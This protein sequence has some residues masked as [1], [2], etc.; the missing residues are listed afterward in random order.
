MCHRHHH[1]HH[2][3]YCITLTTSLPRHPQRSLQGAQLSKQIFVRAPALDTIPASQLGLASH[4]LARHAVTNTRW[5]AAH[6]PQQEKA[7]IAGPSRL[8]TASVPRHAHSSSHSGPGFIHAAKRGPLSTNDSRTVAPAPSATPRKTQKAQYS[9]RGTDASPR[10]TR[11]HV[12]DRPQPHGSEPGPWWTGET[13]FTQ[14]DRTCSDAMLDLDRHMAASHWPFGPSRPQDLYRDA[15]LAHPDRFDWRRRCTV[16]S[17]PVVRSGSKSTPLQRRK[18]SASML[19]G[20]ESKFAAKARRTAERKMDDRSFRMSREKAAQLIQRNGERQPIREQA[21]LY[22]QNWTQLL[23]HERNQELAAIA[24]RRK[25]PIDKLV[26]EGIAI[27]GLQ[28]YWQDDSRRHFGKKVAVFKLDAAEPLPRTLFRAGDK[29]TIMPSTTSGPY[30]GQPL[31]EEE[32]IEAEVVERQRTFLR[33]KFDERDEDVDLVACPSWRLDYG[34]NDLTF[35]RIKAALEAIEHDVEFIETQYGSRFQYILSGTRLSDVILGIEP[36]ADRVT[37]GAFWEDARVQSWY[38]RFSRPDPVVVDGDPQPQLNRSQTQAVAMML[39]ERVSLI[40]GPPGTGKTRTIVTAIKLLKQEFQ[41]P[42]PVML[43]AHTNV[44]VDNLADG[45][46]KA[47][48]RVVRIGPS[49]RARA[50][51]DEF[52]LDAHFLRHPAKPRLDDIKRRMDTLEKLKSDY[53]MVRGPV[54]APAVRDEGEEGI[55][56]TGGGAALSWEDVMAEREEEREV[57]QLQGGTASEEYESIKKRL[58][59]LKATYFFLRASIRGE[60]LNGA[61]VICGSAIAAGSPELDMIDLPV[62]FFDEASMATEPVSLVPLMKGCRHLS[63]IGDHKQLP[64]VVTSAE[65]K[66]GGL[67]KSLFERLI[68]STAA[69]GSKIPSTMLNVQFRMHPRLAEFPNKT[70]YSGALENGS[71]TDKIPAV[72]SEYWPQVEGKDEAHRLCFIDHKGR[73]SK[74]DNSLSLCNVAE[75][76]LAVDVAMDVLRRNPDLTGDDIGIVTP[77][78]GQQILLEKMLHNDTSAERRRAAGALGAR[79]SQL[80]CIDVHTV[81]GFEGREK[82]VILFSTVRTNAQGYV[83][84]LADGRRLNVALTRAQ[85]A[86]FVLG[87]IDTF[88][89]AQLSEA[90][91][92]RVESPDLGALKSYAEYLEQQGAVY[93]TGQAHKIVDTA[94]HDDQDV[95]AAETHSLADAADWQHVMA[96]RSSA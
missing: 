41:V 66:Q 24:E 81:D 40:Q 37:R 42:H 30:A 90:A 27:D 35:E 83:G 33:L 10:S 49:A 67:S 43:A 19:I 28:A 9:R 73:E 57:A 21:R 96:E 26:D 60:I 71:G 54:A 72:E 23:D 93:T 59:R 1:D 65:A 91:Y 31:A 86:L 56:A 18:A 78:A 22:R 79:S 34:F 51:I 32:V 75:A 6:L 11:A 7:C 95:D 20:E 52:T 53:E 39:R 70:F 2:Y 14:V 61:D 25:A 89:N 85:S 62:V 69:D 82:K 38:D 13:S 17:Q 48:L 46:I 94:E 88:K 5:A 4:H 76:R 15:Y 55:G 45:C 44:A 80:G 77:Y 29:V 92:S 50:G 36:P 16:P 63:I 64:P 74:A 8:P 47:G 68:E 58:N 84:F 87:N 3:C 12:P